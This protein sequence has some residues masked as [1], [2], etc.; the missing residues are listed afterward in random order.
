M[1][2]L[3][4][5][6]HQQPHPHQQQPPTQS[7]TGAGGGAVT[8]DSSSYSNS[9][10]A[11]HQPPIQQQHL[12]NG[13]GCAA[14]NGT[15][16]GP[17]HQ[18]PQQPLSSAALSLN[19]TNLQHLQQ[20]QHHPQLLTASTTIGGSAGAPLSTMGVP[21]ANQQHS[22]LGS[23]CGYY[24]SPT[25]TIHTPTTTETESSG[26]VIPPYRSQSAAA[27]VAVQ[28]R[29]S[30]HSLLGDAQSDNSSTTTVSPH[31]PSENAGRYPE[32]KH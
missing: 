20:H 12:M 3:D 22:A 15:A 16:M 10:A 29:R 4:Q 32:Y 18:H 5:Q 2:V 24:P 30:A 1:V 14:S 31:P 26:S 7:M 8:I 28:A 13:V 27:A 9:V 19:S 25:S 23:I 6:Q 21:V 17:S 11:T